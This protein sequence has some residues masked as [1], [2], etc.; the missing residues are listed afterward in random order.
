MI[1]IVQLSVLQEKLPELLPT[2]LSQA[3]KE[4]EDYYMV[5]F[6]VIYSIGITLGMLPHNISYKYLQ[7][8][9]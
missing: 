1:F 7:I 8:N 9:K 4:T 5:D 3:V 2:I 6:N